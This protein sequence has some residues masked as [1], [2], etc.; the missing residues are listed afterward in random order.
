M[1]WNNRPVTAST[2][3]TTTTTTIAAMR[4]ARS[5]DRGSALTNQR[6]INN[7]P[8]STQTPS[9]RAGSIARYRRFI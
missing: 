6:R 1:A 5:M 7:P 4:N 8:A 9:T 2:T 3:T